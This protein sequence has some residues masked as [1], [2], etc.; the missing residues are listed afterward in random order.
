M[1]SAAREAGALARAAF[2]GRMKT[3]TKSDASPVTEIDLAIDTLL[4]ERLCAARPD[5]GWLSEETADN[6]A[7]LAQARVFIVD[8]IDGTRAF[9][10]A[11]PEFCISIGLAENG[12]AALGC[13]YNP[14]LDEM[15]VGGEG[16][17][18][19]RNGAPIAASK[20][21]ALEGARM[22]GKGDIYASPRWPTPW[23]AMH[24][25]WRHSI[26]YRLALIAAGEFDGAVMFGYKNEWD[27]IAG[28]AILAAAGGAVTD[29]SGAPLRFNQ[30]DPRAAGCIASGG[31]LHAELTARLAHVAKL[32]DWTRFWKQIVNAPADADKEAK[33]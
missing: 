9:I 32:E 22:S 7:R 8:P 2:G 12:R 16:A 1:E 6:P 3:F 23:P 25:T 14:I 30:A 15:F 33:P 24:F 17:P 20:R 27:T 5:Y 29:L 18:A 31:P 10:K 4:K 28:A 11:L 13:V 21:A 19:T 26:A